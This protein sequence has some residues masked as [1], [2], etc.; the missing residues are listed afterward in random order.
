MKRDIEL[1]ATLVAKYAVVVPVLDERS[2]RRWAAAESL[3]IGYGGDAVVSSGGPAADEG[4]PICATPR[5]PPEHRPRRRA[6]QG[7]GHH[8]YARGQRIRRR[9]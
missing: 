8:D 6:V 9:R 3:A 4:V 7:L 2:R 1:E 5:T